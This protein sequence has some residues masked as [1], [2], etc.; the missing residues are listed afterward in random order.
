MLKL[1]TQTKK[2][3]TPVERDFQ[4]A[5]KE[6]M[7]TCTGAL[8]ENLHPTFGMSEGIPDICVFHHDKPAEFYELKVGT[9]EGDYL[10][11]KEKLRPT[12]YSWVKHATRKGITTTL[13]VGVQE[14]DA[15]ER[16]PRWGVYEL[17][18]CQPM[19]DFFADTKMINFGS[20][21]LRRWGN[22]R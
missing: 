15:W 5:F 17:T 11:L 1:K 4:R 14:K 20:I 16:H 21:L 18:I 9:V 12:Q 19:M 6:H 22:V 10:V 8:V 13:L 3:R 7:E 2:K